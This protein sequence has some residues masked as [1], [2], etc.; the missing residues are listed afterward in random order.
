M[1]IFVKICGCASG[2][3]VEAIAALKPDALGFILWP[4]SKRYVNPQQIAEWTAS[5]PTDIARVGVFV[6]AAPDQIRQAVE[7]AGLDVVQL[8]G[9]EQR[10]DIHRLQPV[11]CWKV[12][13]LNRSIPD[14]LADYE[15]EALLIDYHGESQPGG[16]GETVDWQAAHSFVAAAD[17]K[18]VLAGGL[19]RDNVQQAIRQVHP[20]GVD[21]SS[22]V[23]HSPGIKDI[24]KVKDFIEQCRALA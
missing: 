23:E 19:N 5:V 10:D 21:V 16:T 18:V 4:G 22:G 8:H 14:D 24:E 7:V 15:V 20:W 1:G 12:V 9:G 3:D 13:H 11:R 6:D 2:R 17:R